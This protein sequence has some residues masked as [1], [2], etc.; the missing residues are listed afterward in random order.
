MHI[1]KR[2]QV[3]GTASA[4]VL[5]NKMLDVFIDSKEARMAGEESKGPRNG[6]RRTVV[7]F[8]W[9][10]I[11]TLKLLGGSE[12]RVFGDFL[13]VCVVMPAQPAGF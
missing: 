7:W 4:E 9:V 12:A 5:M 11:R 3:E 1:P 10:F 2:V 13:F 8:F 6:R